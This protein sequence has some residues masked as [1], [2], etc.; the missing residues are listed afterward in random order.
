MLKRMVLLLGLAASLPTSANTLA[1]TLANGMKVIIKED[2]RA[3]VAVARIRYEVGSVDEQ[4]G[5]TGLS[6]AL[7]HMMFKGTAQVPSGEF[8]RRVSALGGEDNAYTSNTGTVY[9]ENI[10]AKNLPKVLEMEADRMANLN[11]NDK[12]FL[13]EMSVIREERRQ[14]TEDSPGGALYEQLLDK[15]YQKR[16]NRAPVIGYMNDLRALKPEDLRQWYRQWYVPNNATL[17][18]VGDVNAADTLKTVERLFGG[19]KTKPLPKRHD[20]KET[21]PTQAAKVLIEHNTRQPMFMSLYQVPKLTKID[22]SEPYALDMLSAVLSGNTASRYSKN[23]LRGQAVA[24]AASA[25]YSGLG[26]DNGVFGLTGMPA[27]G[28]SVDKLHALMLDEIRRIAQ[29]GVPESELEVIRRQYCADK[30]YDKDA[31]GNQAN[32]ILTLESAGLSYQDEDEMERRNLAV[33]AAAIQAAAHKI[34]NSHAV[35]GIVNPRQQ[36]SEGAQP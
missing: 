31:I 12:D 23:L 11:F 26:R 17:V 36:H 21:P 32:L 29:E 15:M 27:E 8:S 14:R 20:L 25:Y 33:T 18:V 30:I 5:K 22:D 35:T 24:L 3:P 10:A 6:H 1:Q 28:V 16:Y 9:F 2:N 34:L 13:N 7:E 4:E 19:L